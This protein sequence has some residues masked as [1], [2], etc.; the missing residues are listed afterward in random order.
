MSHSSQHFWARW[1]FVPTPGRDEALIREYVRSL[2]QEEERLDQIDLGNNGD[3][4]NYSSTPTVSISGGSWST[5]GGR[6]QGTVFYIPATGGDEIRAAL[7]LSLGRG[8][9]RPTPI[10]PAIEPARGIAAIRTPMSSRSSDYCAIRA[11]GAGPVAAAAISLR[12]LHIIQP[13]FPSP[14]RIRHQSP[15]AGRSLSFTSAPRR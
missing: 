14:A 7:K 4:H 11:R 3:A 13:S 1:C 9:T 12:N 10:A 8:E 2:E 6:G 15:L 5:P